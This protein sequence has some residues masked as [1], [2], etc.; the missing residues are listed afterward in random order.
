MQV[1]GK[2]W[3]SAFKEQ[4]LDLNPDVICFT[5]APIDDEQGTSVF[6]NDV[7][8]TMGAADYF[9]DVHERSWLLEGKH[10]GAALIGKYP[11]ID[12][13]VLKLQ[14]PHI[15]A[16]RPD[17]THWV[18]H[19][20]SIQAVTIHLPDARVRL[21]NLHYFPFHYFHRT[22]KD[23]E[24][25]AT[26]RQLVDFVRANQSLPSIVAG[27]F[28]NNDDDLVDAY[29][30]LFENDLLREAIEF[31]PEQFDENYNGKHQLDHILYS[32]KGL[33]LTYAEIV[34]DKA[35]HRGILADFE[36]T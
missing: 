11:L 17:G 24:F 7:A 28:N 16:D 3:P 2:Y 34:R 19:S 32:P 6:I 8:K 23:P 29:P 22:L 15:E 9:I 21:F 14:A 27:D 10:Y 31:G 12:Y 25:E 18:M 20:K 33:K 26:R 1:Y 35:D 5:E 36:L 4:Y 13:K 30:E